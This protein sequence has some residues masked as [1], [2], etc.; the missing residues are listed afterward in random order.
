MTVPPPPPRE[1]GPGA[2]AWA[3][4]SLG[5]GAY[6]TAVLQRTS[7]GVAGLEATERFGATASALSAFTVLQLAVYA[8]LQVPAGI[9]LDRFGSRRLLAAGALVMAAGQLVLALAA[10]V[11]L[12]VLG[13]VLVGAGDALTFVSVLRLVAAWFPPSRVPLVTQ[14]TGI[15]GQA[16]QVLSAVPLV[17]LLTGPGWTAAFLAAAGTGALVAVLVAAGVRDAPGVRW[18]RGPA[19]SLGRVRDD[20]ASAWRHPG[21]RLGLWTHLTTQ[22]P[23]TVFSLTWGYPFLVSAQG[24]RPATA[25]ALLTTYVVAGAAAGP[26]LGLMAG[27]HPLRRSWLVLGTVGLNVAGWTAVLA[28]PGPAP[29]WLLVVLVLALAT[30][31]PGSLVGLD[32]ART[33]NP[34][35]RLGTASGLVNIGGFAASLVVV[36]A[37]GV[38]LD[39]SGGAYDLDGFRAAFSAQYPVWAVGVVGILVAR[40]RVRRRMAAEG[41]VVPPLRQA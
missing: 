32:Y 2:R 9:L 6:V 24:L 35:Q 25:S 4:W 31:G 1:R 26:V 27:R 16:G 29:V 36:M 33:Y 13:R 7:L 5:A 20:L 41:V 12:A 21:T 37:V 38:V 28:L 40:R 18:H 8:G 39:L 3:V 15:V 19:M 14:L 34:A 22:F 23:G 30:G 17:A 11:P 10:T